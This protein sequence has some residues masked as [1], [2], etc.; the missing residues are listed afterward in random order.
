MNRKMFYFLALFFITSSCM[1]E[2]ASDEINENKSNQT[3]Q[4]AMHDNMEFKQDDLPYV[5]GPDTDAA[6]KDM[7][8]EDSVGADGNYVYPPRDTIWL[9]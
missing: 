1:S 9:E 3:E 7:Y 8:G 2:N 5:L 6:L 4:D